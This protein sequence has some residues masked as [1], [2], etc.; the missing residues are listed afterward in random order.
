M[1][2]THTDIYTENHK[3]NIYSYH[4]YQQTGIQQQTWL[5]ISQWGRDKIGLHFADDNFKCIFFNETVR[6]SINIS[7]AFIAE[8]PIDISI[9]Y[10]SS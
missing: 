1:R 3:S 4:K 6:I 9:G 2:S 10:N 7:P 8:S 5:H